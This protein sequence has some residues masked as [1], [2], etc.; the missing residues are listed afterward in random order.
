MKE[1][2]VYTEEELNRPC[3]YIV[4]V[5]DPNIDTHIIDLE[6]S[7][8]Y[9]EKYNRRCL[10]VTDK[11]VLK[12]SDEDQLKFIWINNWSKPGVKVLDNM[13]KSFK[14][15]YKYILPKFQNGLLI[16]HANTI[17]NEIAND[18][19][20]N[21]GNGLD[22]MVY[23]QDLMSI[24]NNEKMRM[25][26]LRIHYNPEF[27]FS[28]EYYRNFSEVYSDSNAIGIFTA[29]YIA[30]ATY[31]ACETQIKKY[32]AFFE[33]QGAEDYVNYYEMNKQQAFYVYYDFTAGKIFGFSKEK[34]MHYMS[35]MFKAI[36]NKPML[37]RVDEFS[38]VY[39]A[40]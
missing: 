19:A 10:I 4:S 11:D 36:E 6:E 39:V 2:I 24:S 37:N 38:N 12:D 40:Q 14:E 32:N 9:V 30:N 3:K 18:I 16:T 35:L 25:N 15:V 29:Q 20:L 31:A 34:I 33:K 26:Y 5:C 13:G 27:I 8:A 1:S 22:F 28:K 23:R 17:T 7:R 21:K